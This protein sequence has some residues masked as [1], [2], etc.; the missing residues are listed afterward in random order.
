MSS[1]ELQQSGSSPSHPPEPTF[2]QRWMAAHAARKRWFENE[3]NSATMASAKS[4]YRLADKVGLDE[5]K[6]TAKEAYLSAITP[7][8]S[9]LR[10]ASS[11]VQTLTRLASQIAL[12]ELLAATTRR[13]EQLQRPLL[14]YIS[15]SFPSVSKSVPMALF[16][17]GHYRSE[18]LSQGTHEAE[19]A[20][21]L[22]ADQCFHRS[23]SAHRY[24][25]SR[26]VR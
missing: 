9:L 6:S 15:L 26:Q 12:F 4:I 13:H 24:R 16:A 3:P 1:T 7:E 17:S 20:L 25:I 18:K 10:T 21:H 2:D 5:L 22:V 23:T 19:I 14:D 8:V 11:H